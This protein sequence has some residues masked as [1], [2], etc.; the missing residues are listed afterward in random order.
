[1]LRAA[2]TNR[3]MVPSFREQEVIAFFSV[4]HC[5]GRTV[6]LQKKSTEFKLLA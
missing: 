5:G 2:A 3:S 6:L 1:M 4:F